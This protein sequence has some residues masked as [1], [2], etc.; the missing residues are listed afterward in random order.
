MNSTNQKRFDRQV[1]WVLSQLPHSVIKMLHRV[2]LHVV[3]QPSKRLCKELKIASPDDLCGYFS[4]VPYGEKNGYFGSNVYLS[5]DLPILT[6]ITIFRRGIIA[7]SRN[8]FG[9]VRR[10]QLREQI[11]ITILHELAHLHG[12]DEDEI[13]KL[14]YG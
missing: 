10:C 2:P 3:D 6:S 9:K 12:I 14:G 1:E 11:K 5:A 8:E 13:D 4:G 7:V